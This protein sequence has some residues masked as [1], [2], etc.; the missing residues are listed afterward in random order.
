MKSY[1][2]TI[3]AKIFTFV[4]VV[5][6]F[7]SS[8][9]TSQTWT[10][11]VTDIRTGKAVSDITVCGGLK[12]RKDA[13]PKVKTKDDGKFSV[14]YDV[15]LDKSYFVLYADSKDYLPYR[16]YR[17]KTGFANIKLIPKV[18]HIKGK[19]VDVETGKPLAGIKI[20]AGVPGRYLVSGK[21]G[22]ERVT[23]NSKGEYHITIPAYKRSGVN[24]IMGS[25]D[26][27]ESVKSSA[28]SKQYE[29]INDYWIEVNYGAS[30]DFA[31]QYVKY[32]TR[33]KD[34]NNKY[35]QKPIPLTSSITSD[36]HTI[37]NFKL[38]LKSSKTKPSLDLVTVI[39]PGGSSNDDC[40]H[41]R[42]KIDALIKENKV[43]R[44][45]IKKL[46]Q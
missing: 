1:K 10:G 24:I 9:A 18:A 37:V 30:T 2:E 5:S 35:H 6:I 39:P 28:L 22:Y 20:V 40:Q 43:L 44:A 31:K 12:G 29:P 8:I 32:S 11:V 41:L 14:T 17:T 23:T 13:T 42:D 4:F 26:V 45:E 34:S 15:D 38:P 7:I 16:E 3:N 19:V 25:E 27:P 36:L 33:E 21:D 46:K